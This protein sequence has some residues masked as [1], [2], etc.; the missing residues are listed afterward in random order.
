MKIYRRK[1]VLM[2]TVLF[3]TVSSVSAFAS[4][5]VF[6]DIRDHWSREF[7]EDI[8]GRGITRGY[9]DA[10]FRP[11][12]SITGLEVAVMIANM[13]G[14]KDSKIDILHKY[15]EKL[16]EFQIPEQVQGYVAFLLEEKVLL[17]KEAERL[18]I[19]NQHSIAERHEV[20]S[21]IGRALVEHAYQKLEDI[22]SIPYKDGLDIPGVS[23]P[24]ISLLL[25][26]GILDE[27]SNDGKFLPR[28]PISRAEIAKLISLTA[29]ILDNTEDEDI[30]EEVDSADDE[31]STDGLPIDDPDMEDETDKPGEQTDILV[32]KEK[33]GTIDSIHRADRTIIVLRD[34]KN[35]QTIYDVEETVIV[36]ID[37]KQSDISKLSRGQR[38]KLKLVDEVVEVITAIG[39]KEDFSGHFVR[40]LRGAN[41]VLTL[42]DQRDVQRVF[43]VPKGASIYLDDVDASLS[44]FKEGDVI[45]IYYEGKNI[46]SIEGRT[47][48]GYVRGSIT[49][50]GA[51][52]EP[53]IELT[54]KDE[55]IIT[56]PVET[57][58]TIIRDG[59]KS[60]YSQLRIG[61]EVNVELEYEK[62]KTLTASVVKRTVEGTIK[63]IV[64]GE[65]NYLTVENKDGIRED[66]LILPHTVVFVSGETTGIYGLR[67]NNKVMINIES[68]E[69]VYIS[70]TTVAESGRILGHVS[71]VRKDI[72]MLTIRTDENGTKKE[73][74]INTRY[75]TI[76]T[77]MHGG[78]VLINDIKVGHEVLV[79]GYTSGGIFMAERVVVI[80]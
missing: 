22:S 77:G 10:T 29:G 28:N 13:L 6:T 11:D 21:Y 35:Q 50:K 67:Y 3:I 24:Y 69:V 18:V 1:L 27:K 7:V 74:K 60:T 2:F 59:R 34:E 78:R 31:N 79:V 9:G 16:E 75:D 17:E 23:A 72:N 43:V 51:S 12:N 5:L 42:K 80:N 15:E 25:K 66:F 65:E 30:W 32:I 20:A 37:G 58:T 71:D 61:D 45:N 14:Y 56:I 73:L 54:T 36:T 57:N 76:F 33:E 70:S 62:M 40:F 39:R 44:S 46:S 55:K 8:Y 19:N 26:N 53:C 41:T 49:N 52:S 47:K 64:I 68:N 38:I 4:G 63:K 48:T